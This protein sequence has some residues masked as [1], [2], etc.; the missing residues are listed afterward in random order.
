M[1]AYDVKTLR[2]CRSG[3]IIVEGHFSNEFAM[4]ELCSLLHGVA[5]CSEKLGVARFS[6]EG[7]DITIYRTGR[8][9]VHGVTSEEEAIEFINDI[10]LIVEDAFVD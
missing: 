2:P 10:K 7:C 9:D 6:H 1:K 3:G 5:K 8:V 4:H